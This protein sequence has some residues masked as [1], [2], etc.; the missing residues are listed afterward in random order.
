MMERRRTAI[1][2]IIGF[3]L[4]AGLI[5]GRGFF[6]TVAYAFAGLLV[7]SLAWAWTGV[8]ALGLRRQTRARR[9]QVGSTL[10]ENFTVQ[11]RS[12]IPKLWLEIYDKSTLPNHH[13][14]HVVTNLGPRAT[15]T[16]QVG[17]LCTRRGAYTLGPLQLATGDPFGLFQVERQ[18]DAT[19]PLIVY[20]QTVEIPEFAL[21]LGVLSGGDALR[22]RTHYITT[23]AAGIR[24]YAPGDSFSRIHWPSSA[25]KD[26]LLVKEFELDP[27]ADVWIMLDAER[28]VHTGDYEAVI[29]GE[30]LP[31]RDGKSFAI[32]PTTEEYAVTLAASIS[33]YFLQRDRA[34]GFVTHARRRE[35]LP[36][37]RGPRQ[38]TKILETLAILEARGAVTLGQLMAAYG[39]QLPRGTTVI[40]ITPSTRDDWVLAAH[41]YLQRGLRVVAVIVEGQSFGGRP[42]AERAAL[43]LNTLG[44]PTYMVRRG[45]DIQAALSQVRVN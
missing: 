37:D 13:A 24:D 5:T 22:R 6:Y 31:G 27:L 43:Q 9:A 7:F 26:R 34:V 18:V 40:L 35:T 15:A 21:P 38:L 12:V 45:D 23:N 28:T 33:R 19:S 20:P 2:V 36:A 17:T 14:S 44:V 39:S 42:G 10:D 25:R 30:L 3:S 16:W 41:G 32:P 1:Y 8:S 11:N 29:S 4:L